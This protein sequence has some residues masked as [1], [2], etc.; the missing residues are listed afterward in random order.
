M[1][2]ATI[3]SLLV[4]ALAVTLP[5]QV[6][7]AQ[8]TRWPSTNGLIV[9]RSD[10]D[11][12]PDVFTLDATTGVMTK[13]TE[14]SG[15]ADLS[16]A[17]SPDGGRIAFIR[18][19]GDLGRPDLYVM[20]AAGRGRTRL[21]RT[22]VAERDP[23][24][25]PDGTMLVYSAR[26]SPNGPFRLFVAKADGSA[27]TQLTT[28]GR[29]AADRSPVFSPDGTRIAF[30]SDRDGGFPEVYVMD[31]DGSRANRLT[32]NEFVDGN[33]AWT[34][35]GSR[36]VVER[37]CPKGSSELFSID[38]AT[39]TETPLTATPSTMEFDPVVSPDGS[40]IA[41]VAFEEGVGDI[42]L[43]VM[44]ADGTGA[45]RLTNDPA[46]DLAPD[47]QPVAECTVRGTG[48]DDADLAGT[49]GDDVICGLGG[50]DSI[51][52]GDGADLVLGGKGNDALEGQ[53]GNDVISG[54]QGDD[55]VDGGPGY[56]MLDGGP[57]N[58]RCVRG[59]DGAFA[60]LC[61]S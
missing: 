14:N 12:E 53:F 46:P 48:G 7:T 38:V 4:L 40:R 2:R 54:D 27:R 21:T 9:F 17:W 45:T 42:D 59:A 58:D 47:W 35:D 10:R 49:E 16:P 34:P 57:G 37:C 26:T 36:V 55:L 11:G 29:G 39:H 25:S 30:G 15:I 23:S 32:A 5:P 1:R 50:D 24:W 56:D 33:P 44:N 19:T 61:E 41:Y 3:A 18:R 51:V 6:A 52:A 13:L 31:L 60:R 20:T 8:S 22:P 43:W 28:Q